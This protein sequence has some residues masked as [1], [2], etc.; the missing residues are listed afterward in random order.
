MNISPITA[1]QN[2]RQQNFGALSKVPR[3]EELATEIRTVLAI[4]DPDVAREAARKFKA[5]YMAVQ[6]QA[7]HD[8]NILNIVATLLKGDLPT[9]ERTYDLFEIPLFRANSVRPWTYPGLSLKG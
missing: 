3:I 7:S 9:I 2:Y 5:D 8:L 6:P 1:N 4:K